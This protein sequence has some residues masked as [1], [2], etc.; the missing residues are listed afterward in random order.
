MRHS[1]RGP[2]RHVWV[3]PPSPRKTQLKADL[4]IGINVIV[5]S[6]LQKGWVKYPLLNAI[7]NVQTRIWDVGDP[8]SRPE[9]HKQSRSSRY[10][11]ISTS[12]RWLPAGR[13]LVATPTTGQEHSPGSHFLQMQKWHSPNA[14]N[15]AVTSAILVSKVS[16]YMPH[17]ICHKEFFMHQVQYWWPWI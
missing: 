16:D 4:T 13:T 12:P 17:F 2:C 6:R 14:L 7:W 9:A 8:I 15:N 1:S 5:P 3:C 10:T 11:K